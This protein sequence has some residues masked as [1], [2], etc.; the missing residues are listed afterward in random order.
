MGLTLWLYTDCTM[1]QAMF[2]VEIPLHR[3]Y[4]GLI[5]TYTYYVAGTSNE[6]DPEMAIERWSSEVYKT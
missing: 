1:F 5:R 3:P 2:C 4:I 6:S